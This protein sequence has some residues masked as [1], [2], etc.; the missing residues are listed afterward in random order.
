MLVRTTFSSSNCV[1]KS[2]ASA[3]LAFCAVAPGFAQQVTGGSHH[4]RP[5]I[6]QQVDQGTLVPLTGNVRHGLNSEK[7]AGMVEDARPLSLYLV[8]QR[9][10]EQTAELNALIAEQQNPA[11]PDFHKWLTPQQFGERFGVAASDIAALS[12]WLTSQGFQVTGVTNNASMITFKT[13][14][15][16]VR[17]TFHTQLHY[18]NV[19]GG[20][21]AAVA[22]EPQIPAAFANVIAGIKGLNQVPARSKRVGG[23]P[24]TYDAETHR[25][26]DTAAMVTEGVKPHY[27]DGQGNYDETPRDFYTIYNVNKVFSTGNLGAGATISIPEPTDMEYGSVNT[28]TGKAAGGDVVTFRTLFGVAGTLNMTVM[29]GAGSVTCGDPGINGAVGEAALD[30]EWANALAPNSHLIFMS[31]DS[32][33]PSGDGFGDALLA[34][35][36]NNI[37]DIISSSYG[38]SEI[39]LSSSD[40]ASQD[41]LTMQAATQGQTFIDAAGD[42]GS[43]DD[44][45]NTPGTAANGLNVDN[46]AGTP[47]TLVVGGTD[48]QDK[49]DADRGGLP[50]STYWASSNTQFYSDALSYIPETPWNSSCADS[51]IAIDPLVGGGLT[52][53]QYCGEGPTINPNINGAIVGG[54]GGFSIH[55]PQPAYQAGTPGLV[56]PGNKRAVPDISFF[57]ANGFWGHGIIQCDSSN[58]NTACTSPSTFEVAGGTS[59]AAP[60]AAGVIG[61]LVT[62]TGERQGFINPTIY[63]LAKAQFTGPN[64]SACYA[65][66]QTSNTGVTTSLPAA[67]CIFHDVTTGNND[68]P[69]AAGSTQCYVLPGDSYGLLSVAGA[70][71]LTIGYSSG[72]QYDEATGLGSLDVYNFIT[73]F[74]TGNSSST[75]LNANPTSITAAQ[76]T[77][78]TATV[79]GTVAAGATGATPALTGSVTFNLGSTVLGS[80]TL[81]SGSCM[82]S[83]PGSK[84]NVGNNSITAT[85]TGTGTYPSST[86][87]IVVVNEAA[88]GKTATTTSITL[89]PSSNLK[90]GTPLAV[91]ITVAPTSGTA[92]ASGSVTLKESFSSKTLT[93]TLGSNGK[94][95]YNGTVPAPGT[96]QL[97]A[98]YN[99]S[100]TLATSTSQI[101]Q[102][103]V[104]K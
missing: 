13:N 51:I 88:A 87:N 70:N 45:Q 99:G 25:W 81:T 57:A 38:S 66:G 60:Q 54:G 32:S 72:P 15:A 68:E 42:A 14:A 79:T 102:M 80:C 46:Y 34:L 85:Y 47:L 62:A 58:P 44:A 23:H 39:H 74:N 76:S 91:T 69:C 5:L 9:T 83:V 59:F 65:N 24:V 84:L 2:L 22:S 11:S 12:H 35:V 4:A 33:G 48:F 50:Q 53:A 71:S 3:L 19:D 16:G 61:L 49:Y 28:S 78:L 96:Y 104:T 64:A 20:K 63:A 90:A 77:T 31:C 97:S 56:N 29:H 73:Q 82:I 10:P 98:T 27:T 18:W 40:F 67:S 101:V 93:L 94:A 26:H 37:S 1:A 86:S 89:V 7:E 8:L 75:A 41:T 103:T 55:Y 52:P 17:N 100:T 21:Y 43:A 95:T 36:D 92:V 6:T 30:A